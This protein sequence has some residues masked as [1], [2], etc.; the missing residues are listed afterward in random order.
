MEVTGWISGQ[1]FL[2]T[3]DEAEVQ[4]I[5]TL[6]NARG[7]GNQ[8]LTTAEQ[9]TLDPDTPDQSVTTTSY[10]IA[11]QLDGFPQVV[12]PLLGELMHR[13]HGGGWLIEGEE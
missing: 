4:A 11:A 1:V 12:A 9:M 2:S 8:L 6:L 10:S 3:V 5:T 13:A 7:I